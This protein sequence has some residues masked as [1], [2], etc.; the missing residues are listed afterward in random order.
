[1]TISFRFPEKE[2]R[3]KGWI[4]W[5]CNERSLD[6]FNPKPGWIRVDLSQLFHIHRVYELKRKR[7]Q[8]IASKKPS[9]RKALAT[10]RGTSH[11]R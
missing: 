3:F 5:Y 11:T 10:E 9:L 2:E 1:L 6:G 4:V 7:L 8:N